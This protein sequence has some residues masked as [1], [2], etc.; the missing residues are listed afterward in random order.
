MGNRR[1]LA[2]ERQSK[3]ATLRWPSAESSLSAT[4]CVKRAMASCGRLRRASKI[5]RFCNADTSAGLMA[6]ACSKRSSVGLARIESQC[7]L[8]IGD[9]LHG[10]VQARE[11]DADAG[12]G[13]S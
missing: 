9:R 1:V 5:L 6:T 12:L 10:A 7:R 13:R 8:A 3:S 2:I 11:R 4:A